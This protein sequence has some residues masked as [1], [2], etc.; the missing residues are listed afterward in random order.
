MFLLS[1]ALFSCGEKTSEIVIH[2]DNIEPQEIIE[3]EDEDVLT[4]DN[5]NKWLV[6]E[7]MK[8][9]IE[10]GRVILEEYVKSQS[11]DYKNLAI[12]LKE[13]NNLLIKSC[14]MT[15]KAHDELH[16]WVHPHL[17]LVKEL[18]AVQTNEES[19]DVIKR[20]QAS[21]QTYSQF[22]Q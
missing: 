15:G 2:Q 12:H 11:N 8:P 7:D 18:E 16:K 14:T 1:F 17:E 3:I 19:S 22:F 21:Y 10:K 4:L 20:L 13:Q 9:H 5:G 6:N